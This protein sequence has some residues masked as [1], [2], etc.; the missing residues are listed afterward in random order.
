MLPCR[1]AGATNSELLKGVQQLLDV[2]VA[3][4]FALKSSLQVT[5]GSDAAG[6]G[7]AAAGPTTFTVRL[8]GP[9]NLWSLQALAAQRSSLYT[10]H[11]AATVA[12][13]LRASG[14]GS[15]CRLAW[16]DTAVTQQWSLL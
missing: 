9:A 8:E 14:R 16:T 1:P 11:D 5:A 3:N 12:A 10:Q 6:D 2:F 7:P 15:T 4:G 13:F